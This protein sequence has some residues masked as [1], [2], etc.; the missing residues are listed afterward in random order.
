[1]KIN[2]NDFATSVKSLNLFQL[3]IRNKGY[4]GGL[5]S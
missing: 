4:L 5:V 2:T 1:M 3:K